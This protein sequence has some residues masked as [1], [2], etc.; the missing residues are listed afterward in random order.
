MCSLWLWGYG[1][2]VKWVYYRRVL[3]TGWLSNPGDRYVYD[4]FHS[5]SLMRTLHSLL[6]F[7][8]ASESDGIGR[9]R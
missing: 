3:V 6:K 2:V 1:S 4:L 7:L 9:V 5:P 8:F